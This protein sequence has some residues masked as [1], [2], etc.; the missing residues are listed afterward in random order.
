MPIVMFLNLKGGVAKTTNAVAVA[1]CFASTGKR[2]LLV[3]ADH[4]SMASELL[5]GE[6]RLAQAEA[7]KKTLHDLF[8]YMLSDD[9]NPDAMREYVTP[10]ASN[11]TS[12]KK[13][14]DCIPCS[15]RIDE[16]TTNMAKAR[17]GYQSN[18]EFLRRLNRLRYS[19]ARWCNGHYQYTIVDCPPTF[20]IQVVFLL[21]SADYFIL[22]TI[23]DRL[24]IRGSLYLLERLRMRG[25]KRIQCLGTLWSLVR[26]QVAKHRN[27]MKWV[28]E[29][30]DG[31]ASLP[32]P[33]A[34]VIPNMSS[35]A[36]AMDY[37]KNYSSYQAKYQD[38]SADLFENVCK[39]IEERI[40]IAKKENENR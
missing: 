38:K 4:Q 40:R 2:V 3:D 16:F 1:E 7:R 5:L 26:V 17:K 13:N 11:I 29:K 10:L 14:I 31:Y 27:I 6:E 34:T 15:H 19:F 9:F 37:L 8:A 25:Y 24:S 23:P 28:E 35:I 30:R 39:E 12:I 18:E 21:A 22:P 20:V 33:F 36:N 32:Q